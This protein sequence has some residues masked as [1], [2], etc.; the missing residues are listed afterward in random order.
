MH[1]VGLHGLRFKCAL[2]GALLTGSNVDGLHM[3]L[4]KAGLIA[5]AGMPVV[6]PRN[7]GSGNLVCPAPHVVGLNVGLGF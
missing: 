1:C 6:S 3:C 5:L 4:S 2:P 7:S